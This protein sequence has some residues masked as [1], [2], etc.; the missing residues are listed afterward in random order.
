MFYIVK[1]DKE[2]C[3]GIQDEGCPTG[4]SDHGNEKWLGE[5]SGCL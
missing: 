2:L 3:T 5:T 4:R 1:R